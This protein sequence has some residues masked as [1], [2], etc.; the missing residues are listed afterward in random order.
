MPETH[1]NNNRSPEL[2][3]VIAKHESPKVRLPQ[4]LP[5]KPANEKEVGLLER[6][7]SVDEEDAE[8]EPGPWDRNFVKTTSLKSL[9]NDLKKSNKAAAAA[10]ATGA[11]PSNNNNG[12]KSQKQLTATI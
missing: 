2:D 9:K 12:T 1:T 3:F 10:G 8:E 5:S 6:V 11:A 4:R 7:E